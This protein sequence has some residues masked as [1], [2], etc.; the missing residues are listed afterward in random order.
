MNASQVIPRVN[1]TPTV[2]TPTTPTTNPLSLKNLRQIMSGRMPGQLII[3]ITDQCNASCAQCGMRRENEYDRATLKIDDIKRM[4]DAAAERGVQAISF[5]GGEPLLY[6]KTIVEC[7]KHAK[8]LGIPYVRTGTNGFMFKGHEKP[9][10]ADKVEKM[11]V[12]LKEAGFYTFWISVDSADVAVHEK[13]RGLPNT[14]AGFEKALPIFHKVGLY[15]SANL[16]INRYVAGFD[17]PPAIEADQGAA[18]YHHFREGFR[19]FYGFVES[20]GFTIVNCCYPMNFDNEDQKAV[21]T[22]T[23]TDDFVI[24]SDQEKLPLFRAL[25]DTIPEFR[26]RLRIFTPLSSLHALIRHYGGQPDRSYGCRGG[27]DYF[28]VDAQTMNTYPC[29]FRGQENLGKFWD[30]DMKSLKQKPWCKQCDWEC[31]R[32]PS[33]LTGPILDLFSQPWSMMSRLLTDREYAKIWRNDLRY[34]R[35]CHYFN[36][37]LPP[38]FRKLSAFTPQ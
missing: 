15:P 19:R 22:A 37:Q 17:K 24:F 13:N 27:I 11:A 29:G 9:D 21:Y 6:L 25:A 8:S 4:L 5:T 33:E 10:F 23:A 20:L 30:L 16:G 12:S 2:L 31:F 34:Y 3:Q 1:E 26:S 36:A 14:V 35:A 32:D 38:D 18:F 7:A 28:F